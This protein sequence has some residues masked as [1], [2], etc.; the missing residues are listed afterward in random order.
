MDGVIADFDTY[1]KSLIG[2]SLSA[3]PDSQSGWNAL[4]DYR[5][6]MYR[7]L[8]PM[9]DAHEL[10]SG[11]FELATDYG[12]KTAI[13]TAVPKYGRVP[14]AKM[15]KKEWLL[16]HFPFLFTDFNIGPWAEDKQ[17]HCVPGDI[18]IDDSELNIP[19]WN[20]RGGFGI[21]HTSAKD[22]IAQLTQHLNK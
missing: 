2:C 4:G 8:A 20:S 10:V 3:F 5:G 21:L 1:C 12:Y 15:H 19:Q 18:L 16:K 22:S 14:L 11:V 7:H 6:D 9:S 13:L 17:K